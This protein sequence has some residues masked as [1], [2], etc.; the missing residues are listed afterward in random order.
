MLGSH[1]VIGLQYA[2]VPVG[3]PVD[4]IIVQALVHVIIAKTKCL[5]GAVGPSIPA[6]VAGWNSGVGFIPIVVGV[7]LHGNGMTH[8]KIIEIPVV[9]K[10]FQS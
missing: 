3:D 6:G 2:E 5:P 4:A 10:I 9:I 7:G 8:R 1:G